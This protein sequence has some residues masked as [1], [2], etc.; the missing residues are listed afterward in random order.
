VIG[1]MLETTIAIERLIMAG[2]LDRHPK[3]TVV[4]VHS[5]GYLAYQQGRLRH[6]RQ[7]RAS[8]FPSDAPDDPKAFFG[9]I[10]FDCL[11]HDPTALRFLIEQAG[12]ENMLMGTDLPCDMASP[13]PWNALVEAA[14]EQVAT[15]IAETN[16]AE[17]YGLESRATAAA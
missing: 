3:L 16:P 11:T 9:Q 8:A 7:V 13:D 1:N 2:V 12:A 10:R 17:L 6:A 15:R 14:G 5:G 4:I